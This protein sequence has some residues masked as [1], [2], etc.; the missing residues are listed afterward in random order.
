MVIIGLIPTPEPWQT[1]AF[2][3]FGEWNDCPPSHVHVAMH[4][5]WHERFGSDIVTIAGDVVECTVARP[6]TT[7]EEALALATEQYA[8]CMDIVEQG[9]QSIEALAASLM[10]S[11]V[12]SFWW[13]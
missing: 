3:A 6:P 13:D 9:F 7:R 10:K 8:Y 4:K 1:P 5:R 11:A 2:T 12:W